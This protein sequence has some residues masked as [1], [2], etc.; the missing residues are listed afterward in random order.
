[1]LVRRWTCRTTS[2]VCIWIR[3][4]GGGN[5]IEHI[6]TGHE[7]EGYE[8]VATVGMQVSFFVRALF[9]ENESL[10]MFLQNFILLKS[11]WNILY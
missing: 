2:K 9:I 7:T 1:M 5:A 3:Y 10:K 11:T 4:I 8:F 6:P